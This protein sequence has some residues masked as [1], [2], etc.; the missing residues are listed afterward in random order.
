MPSESHSR[1]PEDSTP[2]F[3]IVVVGSSAGGLPALE[4]FFEALPAEFQACFVVA[5]HF[6][7]NH[8]S[9]LAGLLA[10]RT[11]RRVEFASADSPL[12][13]DRVWILPPGRPFR[14]EADRL[15][16]AAS[17]SGHGPPVLVDSLLGSLAKTHPAR[18]VAVILSGTGSDGAV[19]ARELKDAGGLV[20]AQSPH[21]ARFPGMPRSAILTGA[22][23]LTGTPEELARLLP[24]LC[25]P[26]RGPAPDTSF[27]GEE[28][29]A[30][31]MRR[32]EALLK[33]HA[34][35]NL[36]DYKAESVSRRIERRMGLCRIDEFDA[37]VSHLQK[38]P[39]ECESLAKEMLIS[40]TGFFRD[41]EVFARLRET[42]LPGLVKESRGRPLRVWVPGCATGEEAYTL[43]M[44]LEDT[45]A[46][47]G[48]PG[49]GYKIFA[50]D[51]DRHALEIAGQGLYPAATAASIPDALRRRYFHPEGDNLQV[52]RQLR[53]RMVFAKHNIL[54]D[55]P[56][57]RLDLV[58]CR[59]LL[60]YLNPHAQHRVLSMVHFALRQGGVLV[61]GLSETLGD[62]SEDFGAVD[63]KQH[64]FHKKTH[65]PSVLPETIPIASL[66][67]GPGS[68]SILPAS[69]PALQDPSAAHLVEAFTD[70]ILGRFDRVCFVLNHRLEILYSFGN[71]RRHIGLKTGRASMNL[72]DLLPKNL[73]AAL[74]TVAARVLAEEKPCRFGP[75]PADDS[76][77]APATT[78]L[79]ESLR[80]AKDDR[81][82]LLVF[83]EDSEPGTGIE[84]SSIGL[85]ESMQRI[86]ELEE[87]LRASR[88]RLKAAVEELEASNEE[89]QT[90]NEELQ[91][92]NEELQST[93]EEL[94]SVNEELQ[95][96]NN[97]HQ[98]K[99][100]ELTNAKEDL[101]NFIASADIATIFLDAD[102]HIRRFTPSAARHTGLLPHDIGR[103]ITALSHPLLVRAA[104]AARR[105]LAGSDSAELNLPV[106]SGGTIHIRALPFLAK[107][108]ARAGATISF[109]PIGPA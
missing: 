69:P 79:V 78:L 30:T 96:L 59:N 100:L 32:V 60:I 54:K 106:D 75:I 38:N 92:S 104:E 89:L 5:G 45:L 35:F 108:G 7:E 63:Q 95:T 40:V 17:A 48:D 31:G 97:E 93:N 73:S 24:D 16:P 44:L 68:L 80:P 42:V 22:A 19:G 1:A 87:E 43:A 99:I 82:Y 84:E 33:R 12:A 86:G 51:L 70:R 11:R 23:D 9:H 101:D 56:F 107:S 88:S 13:P 67:G 4:A 98:S 53:E 39:A 71:T 50:T 20:L 14:F 2:P 57:N 76:A 66:R 25:A 46:D 77:D 102:L 72:A 91:A 103:L 21:S 41:P 85:H 10:T 18:S 62:R 8:E 47:C 61:L 105:I 15:V 55:P 6:P 94:E 3:P 109:V 49:C 65:S 37:Y 36:G 83:F 81:V 27:S 74:Y 34:G 52:A 90:S 64:I 29:A 28:S 26:R 58:S